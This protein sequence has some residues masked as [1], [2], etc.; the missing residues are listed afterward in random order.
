[1]HHQPLRKHATVAYCQAATYPNKPT[2]IIT[3]FA[4]GGSAGS[5]ARILN[6]KPG[7][8]IGQSTT[9][10]PL[11]AKSEYELWGKLINTFNYTAQ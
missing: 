11:P 2:R 6:S 1:M 7:E 3:G 9:L 4:L 10:E 8:E 5:T